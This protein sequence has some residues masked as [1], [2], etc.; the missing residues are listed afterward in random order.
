[1]RHIQVRLELI[2]SPDGWRLFALPENRAGWAPIAITGPRGTPSGALAEFAT[3]LYGL[4]EA[5]K[6][7]A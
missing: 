1:M 4:T 2:E 7:Q 5:E 6:E 3:A